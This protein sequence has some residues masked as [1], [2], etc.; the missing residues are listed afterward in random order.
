MAK[1]FSAPE[2]VKAPKLDF[3]DVK[4]WKANDEKYIQELKSHIQSLGYT[5][6]NVGEVIQFPVADG[7]AQYMVAS[8][9]PLQLIHLPLGDA[10]DWQYAHLLTAKEVQEK[11]DQDKAWKEM[12]AKKTNK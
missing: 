1:I 5:G 3:N 8:M 10:W 6:K 12:I 9:K 4:N 7:Y 11:I 2:E